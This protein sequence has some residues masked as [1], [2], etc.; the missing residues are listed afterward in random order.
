MWLC[1]IS[2]IIGKILFSF[3][4][5]AWCLLDIGRTCPGPRHIFHVVEHDPLRPELAQ[6][7]HAVLHPLRLHQP[8]LKVH[9]RPLGELTVSQLRE[10]TSLVVLRYTLW[11]QPDLGMPPIF[12][13]YVS[14]HRNNPKLLASSHSWAS[15][16]INKKGKEWRGRIRPTWSIFERL[17][18]WKESTLNP[19]S[20]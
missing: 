20:G 8:L 3:F 2:L 13:F 9:I 6:H 1:W 5:S 12:L 17:E 10:A 16:E 11:P 18:P 14:K 19:R 15:L 7:Q 4:I